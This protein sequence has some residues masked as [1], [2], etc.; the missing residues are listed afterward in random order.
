[1]KKINQ[2]LKKIYQNLQLMDAIQIISKDKM[3]SQGTYIR[4][5]YTFRKNGLVDVVEYIDNI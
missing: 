2:C 1:M 4:A 3:N 5:E